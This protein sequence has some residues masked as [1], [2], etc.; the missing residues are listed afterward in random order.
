[1]SKSLTTGQ[2]ASY[3]GVNFRTVI[4][5]IERGLLK[6]Y[7]LPGR[8][9]NRVE[10]A[11]F[12][13]F[14]EDNEMPIPPELRPQKRVLVIDDDKKMAQAIKRVLT[15]AG[16]D[17][18]L[19]FNGLE[20]GMKIA[21]EPPTVITLDLHMPGMGGLSVLET[22]RENHG[23]KISVVVVSGASKLELQRA[24]EAGADE[25][26]QKPF[27]NQDLVDALTRVC[28]LD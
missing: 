26:I 3:C 23:Q 27:A 16:Y 11:E 5:W 1:M 21:Q 15:R 6:S 12:V 14:L 7:K 2:I 4:R 10:V 18:D 24:Q 9:D 25:V 22:V 8:G 17:V 28:P 13:R 20:A 19:A